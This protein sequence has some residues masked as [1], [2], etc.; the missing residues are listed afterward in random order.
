VKQYPDG[1]QRV[2][3]ADR[4]IF[5]EAGFEAADKWGKE[6]REARENPERHG[7]AEDRERAMRRA[8]AAVYDLARTNCFPYFVTL[9]LDAEKVDRYDPAITQRELRRWL[10]NQV[11]R[12]GLAYVLV[13]EH[14]QDGAIHFHGLVNDALELEDSGTV[15]LPGVKKPRKP[16]SARQRAAWLAEGGQ[17]VYNVPGWPYGF[18]T[19]MK[20]VGDYRAACGYVCK[21]IGKDSQKIGG[22]WYYSGGRLARPEVSWTDVD[23]QSFLAETGGSEWK[24]DRLGCSCCSVDLDVE[25]PTDC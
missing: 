14:H 11:Q 16:R 10:S 12:R 13:P 19:A 15:K 9:T 22:R 7:E 24:I 21:Y 8:R 17:V 25:R 5:R 18:T 2:L 6:P 1:G 3:V 4:A 20:L 23:Y